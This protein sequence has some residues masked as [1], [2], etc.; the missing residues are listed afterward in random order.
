MCGGWEGDVNFVDQLSNIKY[1][2]FHLL[3]DGMCTINQKTT[4]SVA[5]EGGQRARCSVASCASLP[6]RTRLSA[7]P[8]ALLSLR[9]PSNLQPF[10]ANRH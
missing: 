9:R 6:R 1:K 2:A 5:E 3:M 4:N 7:L 10:E 8:G